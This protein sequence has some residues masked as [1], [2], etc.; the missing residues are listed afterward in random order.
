MSN[1]I[2]IHRVGDESFHADGQTDKT[3]PIAAFRKFAN[4]PENGEEEEAAPKQTQR[5]EM[6]FRIN[7]TENISV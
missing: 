1:F 4:A 7:K 2:K 6:E 3:T 5:T